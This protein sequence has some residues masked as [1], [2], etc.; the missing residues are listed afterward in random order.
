MKIIDSESL[1]KFDGHTPLVDMQ[2]RATNHASELS[3]HG[4]IAKTVNFLM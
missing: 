1:A 3:C 4:T 2:G